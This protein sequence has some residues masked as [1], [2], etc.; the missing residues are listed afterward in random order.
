MR[1]G[2]ETKVGRKFLVAYRQLPDSND[3]FMLI[4]GFLVPSYLADMKTD[5]P[6]L[7]AY[8]EDHTIV[9]K[10]IVTLL[11]MDADISVVIEASDGIQL[12]EQLG[13][14]AKLPDVC[15]VDINM[16]NMDGFECVSLIRQ[17]WPFMK[18]LVL[19]A[20]MEDTYI[21]R[22][23]KAGVNGYLPKGCDISEIKGALTAI[24]RTGHFYSGSFNKRVINAVEDEILNIPK[25][26]VKE[27]EVLR[28]SMSDLTYPEIAK[29]INISVR[30]VQGF[31][32]S[33]F[34]KL[35]VHNRASLVIKA[36]KT[37]LLIV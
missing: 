33:L 4:F 28:F 6:L 18:I 17:R 19:T 29:E 22:M 7:I 20:L 23:I 36:I 37:G 8:A 16:P 14:A 31:R 35:E 2:N 9:R 34:R 13:N 25:L 3:L 12:L 15:I 1:S 30:S 11:T 5:N 26:T 32:D 21:W 27:L 10:G 24:N